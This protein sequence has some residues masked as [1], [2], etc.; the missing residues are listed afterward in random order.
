MF[1]ETYVHTAKRLGVSDWTVRQA[2]K[3]VGMKGFVR[4]MR[5]LVSAKAKV[6]RVE[7]AQD[8]LQWLDENP[9]TG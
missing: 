7:R 9:D 4:R 2:V 3:D 1:Q 8:L 6:K 5:A